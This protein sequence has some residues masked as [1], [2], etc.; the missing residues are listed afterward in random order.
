[1]P[2]ARSSQR[3]EGSI[4]EIIGANKGGVHDIGTGS[5]RAADA[6]D[7]ALSSAFAKHNAKGATQPEGHVPFP[8]EPKK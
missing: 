7:A 5:V 2:A 1:M 3:R 4:H 8:T 6:N